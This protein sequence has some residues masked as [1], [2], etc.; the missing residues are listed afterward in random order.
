MTY[1]SDKFH[2][3]FPVLLTPFTED[4]KI[5]KEPLKEQVKYLI[6]EGVHGLVANGSTGEFAAL[7]DNERKQVMDIVIYVVN[8]NVP[9]IIGTADVATEKVVRLTKYAEAYGADGVMI[10]APY[11]GSFDDEDLFQHYKAVSD[12][13]DIPIMVYNNPGASGVDMKPELIQ[14]M[15][16]LKNISYIKESSGEMQRVAEIQ[17][18]CGDDITVFCGC[19]NLAMEMFLMG[20]EGWVVPAGNF[21]PKQCIE[22]YDL[23]TKGDLAEA[24]NQY[25]NLL[26]VFNEFERKGKYVQLGKA[27]LEILGRPYG[28]PR[29][30]LLPAT[31]EEKDML[32]EMLYRIL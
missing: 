15:S 25:N 30:P 32:Q 17:R 22:I 29:K 14:R 2:G 4:G 1:I 13:T 18:L 28:K 7:D 3:V 16:K 31:K 20:A 8:G 10:V 9:V 27:A 23:T 26:P 24:R 21:I 11:Y 5:D 19:D 12:D 6:G